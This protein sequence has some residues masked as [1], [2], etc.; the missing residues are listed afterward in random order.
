M[1]EQSIG[2][3]GAG[4]MAQAMIKGLLKKGLPSSQLLASC[5][6]SQ[7]AE[8]VHAH[9]GIEMTQDNL[10]VVD[11]ADILVLAAKPLQLKAI[12]QQISN[13]AANKKPLVISVAAG[14]KAQHFCQWLGYQASVILAI[15]NTSSFVSEGMTGAF[16]NEFV[17]AS[18]QE[19][20]D[21]ILKSLGKVAWVDD[22]ISID[23]ITAISGSGPAYFFLFVEALES[24]GEKLGLKKKAAQLLA[25]Q[26]ALGAAKML[27]DNNIS[28]ESLRHSVTSKGGT[29]AKA[30]EVFENQ[31]LR[32]IVNKATHA[33]YTRSQSLA[34]EIG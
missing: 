24:A 18:Y 15:P 34:K 12:C 7:T 17:T 5:Q 6:S 31:D 16:A 32:D 3:I 30:I 1:F 25:R 19:Q 20:A 13:S 33:A 14:V 8:K 4:N 9:L 28:A 23:A 11:H 22:E 29:T 21:A 27:T 2:F 26:T 10:K